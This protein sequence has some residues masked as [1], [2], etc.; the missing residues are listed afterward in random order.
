[1]RTQQNCRGRETWVDVGDKSS[2]VPRL[3]AP[4]IES[5]A[6]PLPSLPLWPDSDYIRNSGYRA[7][8]MYVPI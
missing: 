4:R 6:S 1:M 3:G 7:T 8:V 2:L 5:I